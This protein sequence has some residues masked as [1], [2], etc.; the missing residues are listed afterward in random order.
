LYIGGRIRTFIP[1]Q[2]VLGQVLYR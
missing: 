2:P 1:S